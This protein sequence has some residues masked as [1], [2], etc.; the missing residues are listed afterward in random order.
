MIQAQDLRRGYFAMVGGII[1]AC[2]CN[3]GLWFITM[4]LSKQHKTVSVILLIPSFA[5]SPMIAYSYLGDGA[6]L[7]YVLASVSILRLF[8][9]D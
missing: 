3:M 1:I 5:I 9:R 2:V 7:T 4:P 8:L 6:Y